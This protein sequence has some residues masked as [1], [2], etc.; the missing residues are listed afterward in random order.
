MKKEK[1]LVLGGG[2]GG[3]KAALE[4]SRDK[5]FDITLLSDH[6]E[7]RYYPAL[8]HTATGG[9]RSGSAVHFKDIFGG[10]GVQTVLGSAE[11]IDRKAKSVTTR[12][13][14]I[15][16][17]D[18]LIIGLGVVT[19]YFGIP[20]LQ[21][22]S[23][24]IKTNTEALRFKQHLH[25]QLMQDHKPDFNYVVVGGGPTGIELAGAL[26]DYIRQLM[27]NHGIK[28]RAIHVELVE[29]APRLLP[30]MPK[31]T[32]WH[33]KRRLKRLGVHVNLG[34]IVQGQAADALTVSGKPI[35]SHT[36]VWTAGVTNHPFFGTNH[37]VLMPRGKVATDVYLQAEDSIFVIGDNANTPYS[38]LAQT[39]V[40][41]GAFVANNL[42]RRASGK[43]MRSYRPQ[44]PASVI[45]VGKHWA[46][47]N[48]KNIQLHGHIGSWLRSAADFIA[49]KD[50]ESWPKAVHQWSL[51]F[52]EHEDCTVCTSKKNA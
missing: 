47:L 51:G 49:F 23:Y 40:S 17:Y 18:T 19:N 8:Y 33:V 27:K 25:D 21:D 41:D 5:R 28:G 43:T 29:A 12:T 4:L 48:W 13:G 1:V 32:S 44:Q 22:L 7:L 26:P 14:E 50:V 30:R 31:R 34:K 10:T 36:V 52:E 42:K 38:G 20:G 11:T 37:F 46:V 39:A 45:P 3:V 16:H 9:Q 24:G 2:F 6:T 15:Y 35:K